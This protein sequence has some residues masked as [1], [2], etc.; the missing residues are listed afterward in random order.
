MIV[1]LTEDDAARLRAIRLAALADAP[2]AFG[3]TLADS[4]SRD[5][6]AWRQQLRELPTFVAVD[7]AGRDVGMVRGAVESGAPA[8][9]WLLSMWVSPQARGQGHG[10]ALVA[11]LLNWAASEGLTRVLLDVGDLNT[12]AQVLYARHGFVRNGV[13]GTLPPP[14]EAITEHQLCRGE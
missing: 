6:A 8:T 5:L 10:D 11:A 12:Q 7:A 9:A 2:D 13:T 14:R 1:R 4:E 3:S